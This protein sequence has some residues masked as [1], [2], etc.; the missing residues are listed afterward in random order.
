[1][2]NTRLKL[3]PGR[4]HPGPRSGSLVSLKLRQRKILQVGG[5][6]AP[7]VWLKVTQTVTDENMQ[8]GRTW[9]IGFQDPLNY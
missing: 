8:V 5:P 1:M 6:A 3:P 4:P 9:L 2:E 7:F